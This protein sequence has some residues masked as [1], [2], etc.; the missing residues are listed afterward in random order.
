MHGGGFAEYFGGAA[1]DHHERGCTHCL[2]LNSRMSAMSA[3]ATCILY[4]RGFHVRAMDAPD[5]V[6]VKHRLHGPN[7]RERFPHAFE[8]PASRIR[9]R[10]WRLRR[11]CPRRCPT[12]RTISIEAANGTKSLIFG[13]WPSVRFPR[14]MVASWVSEPMGSPSPCLTASTPAMKV[15]VTAPMPGM[16]TPSLPLAEEMLMFVWFSTICPP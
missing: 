6:V 11:R 7:G 1:P 4:R 10:G 14:R 16:R 2:A 15:E 3:S 12:C 13:V 9:R 8:Q 5:I